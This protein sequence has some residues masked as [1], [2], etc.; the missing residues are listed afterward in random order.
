VWRREV[1]G[2]LLHFKSL[3]KPLGGHWCDAL[4]RQV[5]EQRTCLPLLQQAC[6]VACCPHALPTFAPSALRSWLPVESA[7]WEIF[8][9]CSETQWNTFSCLLS[10]SR[11]SHGCMRCCNKDT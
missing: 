4:L 10:Y 1:A 9:A 2:D 7:L 5:T 11:F 6:R 3:L 8:C